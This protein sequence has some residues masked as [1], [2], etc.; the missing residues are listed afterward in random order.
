M[1]FD[2]LQFWVVTAVAVGGMWL[3]AR[4][5]IP[6]TRKVKKIRTTLTVSAS[7]RG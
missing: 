7:K 2:D 3:F 4:A 6:K 5:V 1:P